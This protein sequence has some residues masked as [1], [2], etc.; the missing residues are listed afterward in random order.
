MLKEVTSFWK[1]T[2]RQELDSITNKL[3]A[4]IVEERVFNNFNEE[5][6]IKSA[7]KYVNREL[8]ITKDVSEE[9]K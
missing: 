5:K 4:N 9:D 7:K 2:Y 8:L 1:K 6:V 3:S